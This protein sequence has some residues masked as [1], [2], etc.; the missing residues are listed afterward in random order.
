MSTFVKIRNKIG[1]FYA[2][3]DVYLK[4]LFKFMAAFLSMLIFKGYFSFDTKLTSY[5][6][7]ALLSAV[8]MLFPYGGVTFAD[9][10][11]ILL[12]IYKSSLAAAVLFSVFLV[13]ILLL[14][15]GFRPGKGIILCLVPVFFILKIPFVI[16]LVLGLLT[17]FTAIIPSAIG[18][19]AFYLLKYCNEYMAV[20]EYTTDLTEI[21]KDTVTLATSVAGF[22]EIYIYIAAFVVAETVITILKNMSFDHSWTAAVITGSLIM[23]IITVSGALL[24]NTAPDYVLIIVNIFVSAAAGLATELFFFNVDYTRTEHLRFEDDDYFYYVKAIPKVK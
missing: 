10:V 14:Y 9:A 23:G 12:G 5:V 22:K 1:R 3:Y 20:S 2:D 4:P 6:V 7:I 11:Y 18:V 17:G 19:F 16:P 8:C 21:I 13:L 15:F 24:F